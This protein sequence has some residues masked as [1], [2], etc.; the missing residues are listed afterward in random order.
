MWSNDKPGLGIDIDENF[1]EAKRMLGVVAQE[2]NFGGFEK[3]LDIVH[4][5]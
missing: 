3:V 1:P 2:V 4:H 5:E